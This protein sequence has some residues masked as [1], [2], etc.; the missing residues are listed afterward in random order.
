VAEATTHKDFGILKSCTRDEL[1]EGYSSGTW[2]GKRA[3]VKAHSYGQR[4]R[5]ATDGESDEGTSD[6]MECGGPLRGLRRSRSSTPLCFWRL[7]T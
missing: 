3:D 4:R 2:S 7:G 1:D 6:S 5:F